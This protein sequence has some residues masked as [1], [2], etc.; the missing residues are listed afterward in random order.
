MLQGFS[1]GGRTISMR[2]PELNVLPGQ[3]IGPSYYDVVAMNQAYDCGEGCTNSCEN[4]GYV[5][6]IDSRC[7]CVCPPYIGKSHHST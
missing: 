1:T 3:R 7:T 2:K 5:R 4:D 6:W